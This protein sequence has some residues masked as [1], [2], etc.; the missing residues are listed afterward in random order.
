MIDLTYRTSNLLL[1]FFSSVFH[2]ERFLLYVDFTV[3]LNPGTT[4]HYRPSGT[5]GAKFQECYFF[6]SF[7]STFYLSFVFRLS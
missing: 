7:F 6:I 4:F 3:V 2:L 5:F 1:K